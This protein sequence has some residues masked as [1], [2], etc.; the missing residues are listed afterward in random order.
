MAL[1]DWLRDPASSSTPRRWTTPPA[2]DGKQAIVA[3][4]QRKRGYCV[5]F[6]STMAV[7]ARTLGIPARVA[8]G[9]PPGTPAAGGSS[10]G[11]E[12]RARLAGAVL[13]GRRVGALRAHAVPSARRRRRPNGSR[14]PHPTAATKTDGRPRPQPSPT[15]ASAAGY[16]AAPT[17]AP[18]CVRDILNEQA[19]HGGGI[20]AGPVRIPVS[21]VLSSGSPSSLLLAVPPVHPGCCCAA[22]AGRDT[23]DADRAVALAAWTD[24]QDALVDH[25]YDWDPAD[26][27]RRGAA[28]LVEKQIVAGLQAL[29]RFYVLLGPCPCTRRAP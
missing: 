11:A 13:P 1:Q 2:T 12:R 14:P 29:D 10:R 17:S 26:P 23:S 15:S 19:A 18:G 21:A 27:P 7:M 24:L 4:L 28:R 16:P 5:Q 20:G 25:G 3:F 9:F 8:V 6:A 22:D